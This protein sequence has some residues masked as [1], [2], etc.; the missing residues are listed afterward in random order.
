MNSID[1][2]H[3]GENRLPSCLELYGGVGTIGLN[4]ID[5]VSS[6]TSSDENPN[7]VACFQGSVDASGWP[8][9]MKD[10]ARYVGKNA[11]AMIKDTQRFLAKSD[12]LV[13]DPPRKGLDGPVLSAL[14]GSESTIKHLPNPQ[15]VVYVSCGFDA[16]QR[17]CDALLGSGRYELEHAEGHL[18]FPGSDAIET[19]A[20]FLRKD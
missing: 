15:L 17:D 16:F 12:V 19:L 7:N 14:T 18:L 4:L 20:F 13:V 6:L 2:A 3:G 11:T 9:K 8:D 10:R 5:I 1:N